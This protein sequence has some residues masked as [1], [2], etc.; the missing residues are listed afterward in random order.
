[1]GNLTNGTGAYAIVPP[2]AVR[3]TQ[4]PAKPMLTQVDRT[5]TRRNR[6]P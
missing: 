2:A 5:A 3:V 6:G 4:F 1:M